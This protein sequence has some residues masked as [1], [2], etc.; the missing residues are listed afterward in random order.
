MNVN[1]NSVIIRS[2]GELNMFISRGRAISLGNRV[3]LIAIRQGTV[4]CNAR[5]LDGISVGL[6]KQLSQPYTGNYPIRLG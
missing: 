3:E 4:R 1:N 2:A 5:D 6:A